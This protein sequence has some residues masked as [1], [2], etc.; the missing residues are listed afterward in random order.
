MKI[1]GTPEQGCVLTK[2]EALKIYEDMFT[3][4]RI[5]SVAGHLYREKL[6]RGFLHLCNGQEAIY[7]G[8]KLEYQ[9]GDSVITAYRCHGFAYVM[10]ISPEQI[11]C[12]LTGCAKGCSKGKGGSM[13]MYNAE[14]N[15]FGGNGIVGAQV[16]VGTGLAFAHKY[17]GQKNVNLNF[18][19]DGASNQGQVFESYNMAKLMHLP[20]VY[21]CENNHYGMGTSDSRSS[22]NTEYYTRGDYI[23]GIW[24]DGMDVIAVKQA[25]KFAREYVLTTQSPLLLEMAT[26]RYM[27][28][29]ISDPGLGYRTRAEI[30]QFRK[31]RD[32][33][34][35][36][37]A[38]IQTMSSATDAEFAEIEERVKDVVSSAENVARSAAKPNSREL[39]SDVY[40]QKAYN[41]RVD[42]PDPDL[43]SE[44]YLRK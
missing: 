37:K 34:T 16:P 8:T 29:S 2:A 36:F 6:V 18:Y 17:L 10:G 26:Y 20:V 41:L 39:T 43:K 38:R 1:K 7:V 22:A 21:I 25:I 19:G 32:P 4:R 3:I 35:T 33:I 5:E 40:S 11:L 44:E 12:E 31:E 23:P 9:P 42:T 30:D 28:H 24:V 15:F 27:G 13:H 14:Q